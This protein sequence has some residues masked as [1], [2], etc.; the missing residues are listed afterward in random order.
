[1]VRRFVRNVR[2]QKGK[3][4]PT[5]SQKTAE[6]EFFNKYKERLIFI[7]SIYQEDDNYQKAVWTN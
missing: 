6:V 2:L 1:M 4:Q 3:L 7:F 5:V